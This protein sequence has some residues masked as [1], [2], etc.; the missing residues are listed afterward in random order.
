MENAITALTTTVSANS[1]WGAFAGIVPVL[2]VIVPVS[3]GL[4]FVRR[5]TNKS[6]N[7]GKTKM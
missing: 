5:L 6:A 1:L 2:G 4:Y 3:L 7:T